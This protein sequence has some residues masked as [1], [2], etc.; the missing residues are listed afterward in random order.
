MNTQYC[1]QACFLIPFETPTGTSRHVDFVSTGAATSPDREGA[2]P[3]MREVRVQVK[4]DGA[5]GCVFW[6][7]AMER[8][9]RGW[10]RQ[11]Y[12]GRCNFGDKGGIR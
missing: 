2:S 11:S 8:T 9:T 12:R 4:A 6:V 10:N 3:G 7:R 1:E 5:R